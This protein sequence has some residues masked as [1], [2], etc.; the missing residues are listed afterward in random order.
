MNLQ[1]LRT[2]GFDL[3]AHVP[4]TKQ[5]RVRCSEC[6]ALCINNAPTHETGCPHTVHE[7]AGCAAVI[8]SGQ[9]YCADCGY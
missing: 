2:L 1:Q 8:P 5:Y 3:S 4:F 9:R 7:C 6:Q